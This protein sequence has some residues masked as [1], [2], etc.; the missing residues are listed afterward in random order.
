MSGNI[1]GTA[2][3]VH[4]I[5]VD[6]YIDQFAVDLLAKDMGYLREVNRDRNNLEAGGFKITG[7]I[8]GRLVCLRLDFDPKHG[9]GCR[10]RE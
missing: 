8:E 6:R 9:D 2:K 1:L 5:D 10:G 7:N 4:Q 3:D